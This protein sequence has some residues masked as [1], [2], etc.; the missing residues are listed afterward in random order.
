MKYLDDKINENNKIEK[1]I[2]YNFVMAL[3]LIIEQTFLKN[4]NITGIKLNG[5]LDLANIEFLDDHG[6]PLTF[7]NIDITAISKIKDVKKIIVLNDD[8]DKQK[9]KYTE[10]KS[11]ISE[12]FAD[13]S[14]L[15][16]RDDRFKLYKK[17]MHGKIPDYKALI[18]EWRNG[19]FVEE[20]IKNE[21][22]TYIKKIKEV[23]LEKESEINSMIT[24]EYQQIYHKFKINNNQ[25]K[26]LKCLVDMQD[27]V[28]QNEILTG[29]YLPL[30]IE[31][32]GYN[33]SS[34]NG[35]TMGMIAKLDEPTFQFDNNKEE[36]IFEKFKNENPGILDKIKLFSMD[37]MFVNTGSEEMNRNLVIENVSNIFDFIK[38]HYELSKLLKFNKDTYNFYK[39]TYEKEKISEQMKIS[40]PGQPKIRL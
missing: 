29:F 27:I 15:D 34:F 4:E 36:E 3:L 6:F 32:I 20:I 33:M 9:I 23:N 21:D 19:I 25:R 7:N 12:I 40:N 10:N 38:D 14:L 39:T 13:L 22:I 31:R 8:N 5:E 1:Q 17:Y 28:S 16:N 26:I 2:E 37:K 35:H 24:K 11:I 18:E 30:K